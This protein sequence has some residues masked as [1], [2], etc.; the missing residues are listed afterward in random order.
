MK[1]IAIV[2][3]VVVLVFAVTAWAQT[4]AKPKSLSAEQEIIKLE[5][6]WDDAEVKRDVAFLDRILADDY[7]SGHSDGTVTT[8]AQAIAE[9]KSGDYLVTSE[10]LNDYKVHVYG[11][12]AV[13]LGHYTEKSTTKGKD[14]S[15]KSQST[16]TWLKIAGRWQCVASNGSKVEQK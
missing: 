13:F 6:G 9:M 7:M 5:N 8:K 1:R 2:V 10:V 11:D 15:G 12:T 14:T 4:P 3:C 16:D